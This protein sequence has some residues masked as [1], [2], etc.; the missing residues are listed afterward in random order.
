MKN[1]T[2]TDI[3]TFFNSDRAILMFCIGIALIFWLLVKLSQ[4]YKTTKDYGISYSLPQGKT[5]VESPLK[6]VKATL[7]GEGWELISNYFRNRNSIINFEL[8]E[9]PSQAVNSSAI[10]DKIQGVLPDNIEVNDV[11]TDFIFVQIEN[12][13]ENKVP[14]VLNTNLDFATRFH[15]MD[16][17]KM[18]ID[19]VTVSGPLSII[20]NLK[21]WH[22]QSFE[23][24]NIQKS[25][26]HTVALIKPLNEQLSL[27]FNEIDIILSVEEYTGKD[28]F[29]PVIV[30]NAPDSLKIFPENIKMSF[31]VGLSNFNTVSGSEFTAE[32]DLKNIPLNIEKNTIPVL[33]TRQPSYIKGLNFNPKSVEFFFVETTETEPPSN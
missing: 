3:K 10:I 4:S 32:V 31:T 14:I 18:S 17:I 15:M 33:V 7:E 24:G 28:V 2:K 11:N 29:V 13:A 20:E 25:G 16:S 8:A 9:L 21:E 27:D 19:S 12:Q 1:L 30:K 26:I 6:V 5:F 23:L 22:T